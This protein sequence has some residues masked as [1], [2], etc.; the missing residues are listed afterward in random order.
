MT[1]CEHLAATYGPD[2]LYLRRR[3][4]RSRLLELLLDE[5]DLDLL[6]FFFFLWCRSPRGDLGEAP[7]AASGT[8]PSSAAAASPLYSNTLEQRVPDDIVGNNRATE[9]PSE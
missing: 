9:R 1:R 6:C 3:R 5:L 2:D 7:S 8:A 4:F